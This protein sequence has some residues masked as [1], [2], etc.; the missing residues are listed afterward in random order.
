MVSNADM[1]FKKSLDS[2]YKEAKTYDVMLHFTDR[3]KAKGQI[4]NGVMVFNLSNPLV[5][6]F[7]LDYNKMWDQEVYHYLDQIHLYQ[8][9]QK[10]KTKLN[11]GK[12]NGLYIDGNWPPNKD[13]FILSAHSDGKGGTRDSIYERF[14]N[15]KESL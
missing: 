3:H 5:R 15:S 8:V 10:Y 12:L 4:Q 13:A 2:L 1:L 7:L 6:E 14:L 9:Y 11:F